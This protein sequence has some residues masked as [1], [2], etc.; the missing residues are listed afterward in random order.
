[1]CEN[2]APLLYTD[3]IDYPLRLEN[4]L[5]KKHS[6]LVYLDVWERH[7]TPIQDPDI[8][9]VALGG[10]D[11]ATRVKVVWQ[12]KTLEWEPTC[13]SAAEW[14]TLVEHWQ[15]TQRGLLTARAKEGE[16]SFDPCTVSPE[17]K[18]R[19]AQNQLY[20]VE[21]HQGGVAWD[22][23]TGK[24]ESP[25]GNAERAATF[26][27]SRENG[28]VT[29]PILHLSG[30]E[31][32]LAHVGRDNRFGLHPG[33]WVEIVDDVVEL[34]SAPYPLYKVL[35]VDPAMMWV[36]LEFPEGTTPP[37]FDNISTTHP[38]L[39]RWDFQ[40]LDPSSGYP[41]Q[42]KNGALLLQEGKELPLEDGIQITFVAPEIGSPTYRM[43]DYWLIPARTATG[44][45]EWPGSVND[46]VPVSPHG[47]QHHYAPLAIISVNDVG[48]ITI[49]A[50]CRC[51]INP[52][53]TC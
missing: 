35:S 11:T 44:D 18:Y 19:R 1:L 5:E 31:V 40:G 21:I 3:Q 34:R 51:K 10:P 15:P 50:D 46:P 20:R 6:Y 27:W 25:A 48:K 28:S 42:A 17:S 12:V 39:R 23:A 53:S 14:H 49:E 4:Q 16:T 47:V 45:V 33:D 26:K 9:E 36:R 2:S 24:Q 32:T 52:I 8:R 41:V 30:N 22:G 7:I 37:Y 29:Y 43:G 13:P 38:F